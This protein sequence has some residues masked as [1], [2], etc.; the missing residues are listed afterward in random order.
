MR[1]QG[2]FTT[3]WDDGHP[4]DG[5]V[6]DLL[7]RYD[8]Q[9]TFYI[10]LRGPRRSMDH[11]QIRNLSTVFEIGAH[12]VSHCDLSQVSDQTAKAEIC[13]SKA[14]LEELTGKSCK[15]FCFPKGRYHRS[16][17]RLVQEGGFLGVRTVEL[18][19]LDLPRIQAGIAV[20]PT[21]LHAYAHP[22]LSYLKNT[23]KRFAWRNL[24]NCARFGALRFGNRSWVSTAERLMR[25]VAEEGGVFHV[26]GH[27]WELDEYELWPQLGQVLAVMGEL[28]AFARPVTNSAVCAQVVPEAS[29][30]G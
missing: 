19:S 3:S 9:G 25:R 14:M 29:L 10:P 23:V 6:A 13:D 16:Q 4:S 2:F 26:W 24:L 7:A 1:K 17:L 27:S 21:T 5:R 28:K 8:L 11:A 20:M 30:V 15:M 22:R 12:T 18:M